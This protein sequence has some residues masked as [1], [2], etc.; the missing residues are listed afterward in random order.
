MPQDPPDNPIKVTWRWL[1]YQG[2]RFEP[3]VVAV[4][5]IALAVGG[6][7][8]TSNIPVAVIIFIVA[9][10]LPTPGYFWRRRAET[11]DLEGDSREVLL[12]ETLRPLLELASQTTFEF[13]DERERVMKSAAERVSHDLRA[14][15]GDVEGVRVVVFKLNDDATKMTPFPPAG[16]Q[17]RPGPFERGTPRGDK[18]FEV[19]AGKK[20][21][22]AVDDLAKTQPDEWKGSGDG[23]NTFISA[24]IR[25]SKQGFGMLTVDAPQA[26]TLPAR[27]GAT[28]ALFAAAL[29]MLMAEA[30]RGGGGSR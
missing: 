19:L 10:F 2:D 28:I 30:I 29:G 13:K 14:A 20:P 23:Y 6:A 12:E 3:I 1:G 4:S 16:R 17:D 25:N 8:W 24:P 26:G 18:A 15:F 5:A 27:H 9:A 7:V 11:D 21:F 22:V